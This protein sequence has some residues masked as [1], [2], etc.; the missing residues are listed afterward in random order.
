VSAFKLAE[1]G[2]RSDAEAPCD[3]VVLPFSP[4]L[5]PGAKNGP[6]E[7]GHGKPSVAEIACRGHVST[8]IR[9]GGGQDARP[10]FGCGHFWRMLNTGVAAGLRSSQA[11]PYGKYRLIPR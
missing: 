6:L 9:R 5:K 10:T 1:A 3:W 7:A 2:S 8:V 4:R 11:G